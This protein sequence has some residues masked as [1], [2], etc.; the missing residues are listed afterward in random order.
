MI[1]SHP[2]ATF[3]EAEPIAVRFPEGLTHGFLLVRSPAGDLLGRGDL[4]QTVKGANLVESRLVF[5]FKDGST[6]EERASFSQKRRFTLVRY[7]LTQQGPFFPEQLDVTVDRTRATYDIRSRRRGEEKEERLTGKID[8]PND[9][10]NGMVL[11]AVM[12]LP[13]RASET[14]TVLAFTPE[15]NVIKLALRFMDE[16]TVRIGDQPRKSLRYAFEPDLGMIEKFFGKVL[17]KL[18]DDFHYYCWILTDEVPA[19]VQFEGPLQLL[20]PI[21]RVELVS[22][23]LETSPE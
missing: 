17:G 11:T 10:Y 15:P 8:L 12:N 9:I 7:R 16:Q 21:V 5:T 22:P 18:P 1:L 13:L 19:F 14:I 20:G 6:H 4:T 23:R 2:R 3:T